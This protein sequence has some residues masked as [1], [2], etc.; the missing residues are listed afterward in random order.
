VTLRLQGVKVK[1]LKEMDEDEVC[2]RVRA[3]PC[4]T[5]R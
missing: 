1:K 5:R 2:A 3:R 4:A